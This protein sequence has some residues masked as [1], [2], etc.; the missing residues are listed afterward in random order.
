[1]ESNKNEGIQISD[2][3]LEWVEGDV[4]HIVNAPRERIGGL[5]YLIFGRRLDSVYCLFALTTS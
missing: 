1:M 4:E 2:K 5:I 3:T